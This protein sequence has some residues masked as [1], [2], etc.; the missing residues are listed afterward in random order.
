M[1]NFKA[2]LEKKGLSGYRVAKDSGVSQTTIARLVTGERDVSFLKLKTA[3]KIA[4]ALKIS[5]EE[6]LKLS[7]K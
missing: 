3:D 5:L 7:D 6:L 4:K 1:N 2:F